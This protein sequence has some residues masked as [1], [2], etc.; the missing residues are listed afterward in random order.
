MFCDLRRNRTTVFFGGRHASFDGL[1]S[2]YPKRFG[3]GMSY[4]RNNPLRIA[5][6]I[7]Q[8]SNSVTVICAIVFSMLLV[9]LA[10]DINN[11]F[12]ITLVLS[13]ITLLAGLLLVCNMAR[14]VENMEI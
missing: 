13:V 2:D 9:N 7:Y 5:S 11:S 10:T 4:K 8:K 14:K 6:R 12:K 3:A 1:Y